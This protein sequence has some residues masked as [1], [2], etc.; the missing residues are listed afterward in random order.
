MQTYEFINSDRMKWKSMKLNVQ[1]FNF[2]VKLLTNECNVEITE[3]FSQAKKKKKKKFTTS[4]IFRQI[5][6]LLDNDDSET[7]TLTKFFKEM[8]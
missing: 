6:T 1:Q 3:S 2:F 5:N 8:C 7:V 4:E